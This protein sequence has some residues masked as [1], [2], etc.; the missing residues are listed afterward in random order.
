MSFD[1]FVRIGNVGTI[2]LCTV[3]KI[4]AGVETAV[5]VSGTS[6]VQ[7]EVQKPDGE[8]LT[9]FVATFV[10][11]GINGEITY[12]DNVGIFDVSHRW[13]MRGIAITGST[14]LK[15]S[16]FGFTVDE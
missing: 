10:T 9:P 2:L 5:D 1:D 13:K 15:G 12:T 4:V 7:I 11:D 14:I 8:V 16:W 6:A 3:T